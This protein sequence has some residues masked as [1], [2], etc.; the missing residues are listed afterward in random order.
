MPY[1]AYLSRFFTA[2]TLALSFVGTMLDGLGR[3]VRR[4]PDATDQ[5][6]V[7][8]LHA[9]L[10]LLRAIDGATSRLVVR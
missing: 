8:G 5:F 1:H 7:R 4:L 3:V 2:L 10:Y 6:N 9:G